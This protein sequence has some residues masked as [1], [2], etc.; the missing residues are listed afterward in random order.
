M[1]GNPAYRL[2][3]HAT[4]CI[5]TWFP[6]SYLKLGLGPTWVNFIVNHFSKAVTH[7]QCDR[8][9]A[10]ISFNIFIADLTDECFLSC[11]QLNWRNSGSFSID[12]W[13]SWLQ[14]GRYCTSPCVPFHDKL[15][16][17]LRLGLDQ[18]QL[19]HMIPAIRQ[20]NVC[21]EL[22]QFGLPHKANTK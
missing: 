22:K 12:K 6:K 8:A 20:R 17:V 16:C 1:C 5:A 13:F 9:L 19:W 10:L 4:S 21:N 18:F 14:V 2:R 7:P 3:R 11:R 15:C